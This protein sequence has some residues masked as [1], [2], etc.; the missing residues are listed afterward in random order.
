MDVRVN[1]TKAN[2]DTFQSKRLSNTT[3]VCANS[4]LMTSQPL[5]SEPSENERQQVRLKVNCRERKRMHDLNTALDGLRE[6]MPYAHGPSVRK[7]SKIATLLLAKNYILTLQSSLEEMKRLLVAAQA[8]SPLVTHGMTSPSALSAMHMHSHHLLASTLSKP[9]V[10][11]STP[12]HFVPP[13][14]S[15]YPDS[16]SPPVHMKQ[17]LC[18]SQTDQ[19]STISEEKQEYEDDS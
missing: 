10:H 13:P 4:K 18:S 5:K 16:R 3:Y 12:F 17:E 19:D 11:N 8:T 7:L 6:V 9:L 1:K 14:T 15:F 2:E